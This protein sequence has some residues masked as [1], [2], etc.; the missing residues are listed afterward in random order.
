MLWGGASGVLVTLAMSGVPLF[1][2]DVLFKTPL[3]RTCLAS[4]RVLTT[5]CTVSALVSF[6]QQAWFYE[7]V[8]GM[9][10]QTTRPTAISPSNS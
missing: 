9:L 6:S 3:V 10:T 8:F 4:E 1:K 2:T 5:A 7:G